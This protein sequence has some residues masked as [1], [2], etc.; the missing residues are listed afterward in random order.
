[1][2]CFSS[3]LRFL[4]ALP[5]ITTKKREY[6]PLE[7][8]TA[9]NIPPV[10]FP[11]YDFSQQPQ[12]PPSDEN[13]DIEECTM[14]D[15]QLQRYEL[16]NNENTLFLSSQLENYA[17][18]AGNRKDP[19]LAPAPVQNEITRPM[20]LKRLSMDAINFQPQKRRRSIETIKRELNWKV[21]DIKT[22]TFK[23][24]PNNI[25]HLELQLRNNFDT[26][27]VQDQQSIKKMFH[28]SDKEWKHI[29]K[30]L[31]TLKGYRYDSFECMMSSRKS[32]VMTRIMDCFIRSVSL[33]VRSN[34]QFKDFMGH[35][36]EVTEQKSLVNKS[37]DSAIESDILVKMAE[38]KKI[39]SKDI[40]MS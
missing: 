11:N 35:C 34:I 37:T 6:P 7:I 39:L 32:D 29:V 26:F 18:N 31:S 40:E 23:P 4:T 12:T 28:L 16:L 33:F 19:K 21:L 5:N 3:C 30:V 38:F 1:M 36:L 2:I 14:T 27:Y 20:A 8:V 15:S 10:V 13:Y 9:Q 22:I 24:L 25:F 17:F